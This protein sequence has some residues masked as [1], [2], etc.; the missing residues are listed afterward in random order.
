MATR[1]VLADDHRMVRQGIRALLEVEEDFDVVAEAEDGLTA[2]DLVAEHVPDI[3]VTDLSMPGLS[4]LDVIAG[5]AARSPSTRV[6]VL[7]MHGSDAHVATA[8]RNGAVAFVTKDSG[9]SELVR[10][11]RDAAAGRRHIGPPFSARSVE[12]YLAR[13]RSGE[14]DPYESLTA[15]EREVL[16]LD[17]Q[18]RTA[19]EIGA[20]LAISPRTVEAHRAHLTRKLGLRTKADI[21]RYATSRG[22]AEV[23]PAPVPPSEAQ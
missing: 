22:V 5:C 7:T 3:L 19:A 8:L 21:V 16:A 10:A 17:A 2:L 20:R 9:S 1:I 23:V 15:R 12:E 11:V 14:A 18:G 4:G 6:V 13:A